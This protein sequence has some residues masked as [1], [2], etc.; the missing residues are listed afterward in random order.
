[1][2]SLTHSCISQKHPHRFCSMYICVNTEHSLWPGSMDVCA[3]R[4]HLQRLRFTTSALTQSTFWVFAR[5][6]AF[7]TVNIHTD[8][9]WCTSVLNT[10]N[11]HSCYHTVCTFQVISI[12]AT[13]KCFQKKPHAIQMSIL[14]P[15]LLLLLTVFSYKLFPRLFL[16]A[17]YRERSNTWSH[18]SGESRAIESF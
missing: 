3:N 12:T 11:I 4:K 9:T 6:A 5:C 17:W 7:L 15:L 8:Y 14:M 10:K 13:V 18:L 1:M 16:A 2:I